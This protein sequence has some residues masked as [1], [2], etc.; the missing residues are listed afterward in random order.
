LTDDNWRPVPLKVAVLKILERRQGMILDDELAKILKRE[1]GDFSEKE[2][3]K[4]LM[5]LETRGKIH[6]WQITKTKRRIQLITK[7]DV[8][9]GVEED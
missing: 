4:V 9:L 3:N 8:F 6:V 2:F 7:E 1:A 5:Q